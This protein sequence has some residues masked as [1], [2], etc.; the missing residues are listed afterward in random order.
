MTQASR[1]RMQN[2]LDQAPSKPS[3]E[4]LGLHRRPTGPCDTISTGP[5]LAGV[6]LERRVEEG[7]LQEGWKNV[8]SWEC[9]HVHRQA[10][11]FSSVY[12]RRHITWL[13]EQPD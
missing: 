13:D 12:V 1:D 9:F 10:H 5:P 4:T 6:L 8:L 11:I 2:S 3:P 7:L